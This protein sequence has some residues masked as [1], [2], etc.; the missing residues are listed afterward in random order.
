MLSVVLYVVAVAGRFALAVRFR[1]RLLDTLLH[2]VSVVLLIAIC[3]N[4][5]VWSLTGRGGWK[6]RA[7]AAPGPPAG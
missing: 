4:S 7:A 1:Y 3:I 2:P 6:G 5:M